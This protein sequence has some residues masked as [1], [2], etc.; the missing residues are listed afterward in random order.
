MSASRR[1]VEPVVGFSPRVPTPLALMALI[2][3]GPMKICWSTTLPH[4]QDGVQ[5]SLGS[6]LQP[7]LARIQVGPVG[8]LA[9]RV[10]CETAVIV[11]R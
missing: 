9:G 1:T 5:G 2:T 6:K 3:G 4:V 7:R 11:P 10:N 8:V